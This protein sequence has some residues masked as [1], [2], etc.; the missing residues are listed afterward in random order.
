V[1][2]KRVSVDNPVATG[3]RATA[4]RPALDIVVMEGQGQELV[5]RLTPQAVDQVQAHLFLREARRLGR[6]K[7]P[8]NRRQPP[9]HWRFS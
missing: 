5:R 7:F 3:P 6:T 9:R 2:V 8:N 1:I 4:P